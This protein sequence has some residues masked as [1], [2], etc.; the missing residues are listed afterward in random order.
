MT[1]RVQGRRHPGCFSFV[2]RKFLY[3]SAE[4]YKSGFFFLSLKGFVH[5]EA[6]TFIFCIEDR[7]QRL[8]K[9]LSIL[10]TILTRWMI[11]VKANRKIDDC[12][13]GSAFFYTGTSAS[14]TNTHS[15]Q[16]QIISGFSRHWIFGQNAKFKS[17]CHYSQTLVNMLSPNIIF[18][19]VSTLTLY[20]VVKNDIYKTSSLM[21]TFQAGF[22]RWLDPAR[23][24]LVFS[25]HRKEKQTI[26]DHVV[27]RLVLPSLGRVKTTFPVDYSKWEKEKDWKSG[28]IRLYGYTHG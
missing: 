16:T 13:S 21:K 4:T 26:I 9:R 3:Q 27:T 7:S 28:W 15:F 2:A 23:L 8:V 6:Q 22:S 19:P 10:K 18:S 11:F 5:R 25:H 12:L 1:G 17:N 14:F 20:P 24:P